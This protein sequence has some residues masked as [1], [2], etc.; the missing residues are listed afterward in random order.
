MIKMKTILHTIALALSVLI[1]SGKGMAQD[2]I[3]WMTMEEAQEAVKENPKKILIDVYTSW[4]GPCKMM[5]RNTFT[6]VGIIKYINENFYAVKFNA[7]GPDPVTFKG[8]TFENKQ[9]DPNRQGRNGTH[10]FTQGIAPVNG[11]IAYPTIVYMDEELN[12]IS[13][14]QG[15]MQPG[16]IEPILHFIAEEGYVEG[17]WETYQQNFKSQL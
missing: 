11:R 10:E 1:L 2:K 7:E 12:I 17:N 16:Q 15:Y 9:Y 8:V 5:M 4:C 3:Q 13:P 6:H 14:V